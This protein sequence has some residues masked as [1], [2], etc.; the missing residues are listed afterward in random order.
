[1]DSNVSRRWSQGIIAPKSGD[2]GLRSNDMDVIFKPA[3]H[4]PPHL[5]IPNAVYM[6]TAST[7]QNE[8]IIYTPERKT[9][10]RDAFLKSTEIYGWKVIAWVV[11]HN[12]YHVLLDAPE[13]A[14]SLTKLV[15]S[16][17]KFLARKWN[18]EDNSADRQVWW[19]FWDTCVRSERDYY[20]RLR[21]IFWNSVKHG[22][23]VKPE[24]Y[25]FSNYKEFLQTQSDFDFIGMDEVKDVPEF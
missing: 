8:N 18:V 17:H 13:N 15:A 1:M 6:L 11:L 4:N 5:F 25:L 9:E 16:Y 19:N 10:W 7:Y 20:T 24:D 3:R 21:Y 14:V 12:H 23:A 22:L 2:F